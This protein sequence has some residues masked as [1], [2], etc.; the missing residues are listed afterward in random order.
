MGSIEIAFTAIAHE[1]VNQ[2]SAVARLVG[3][4]GQPFGALDGVAVASLT[5]LLAHK[6]RIDARELARKRQF[7]VNRAKIALGGDH[8]GASCELLIAAQGRRHL[9]QVV[10]AVGGGDGAIPLYGFLNAL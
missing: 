8:T 3:E 2:R 6:V 10:G 7:G 5:Q 1:V 4:A 9:L